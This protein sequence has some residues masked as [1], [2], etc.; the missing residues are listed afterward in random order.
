MEGNTD[1][2][3][4]NRKKNGGNFKIPI[5]IT[6]LKNPEILQGFFM[7]SH[8]KIFTRDFQS[9]FNSTSYIRL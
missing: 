4:G 6:Y 3:T 7:N 9:F 2:A 8:I 5:H 1:M